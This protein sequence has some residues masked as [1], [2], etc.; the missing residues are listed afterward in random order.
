MWYEVNIW[1]LKQESNISFRKIINSY[2]ALGLRRTLSEKMQTWNWTLNI[3][4]FNPCMQCW[5]TPSL[6]SENE[7]VSNSKGH[8]WHRKQHIYS[9][10]YREWQRTS[11]KVLCQGRCKSRSHRR[12]IKASETISYTKESYRNI[13]MDSAPTTLPNSKCYGDKFCHWKNMNSFYSL[14][15]QYLL[16][17]WV[18]KATLFLPENTLPRQACWQYFSTHNLPYSH[19]LYPDSTKHTPK[20]FEKKYVSTGMERWL[21]A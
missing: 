6:N 9:P 8:V 2:V 1:T 17:V 11:E 4:L 12:N 19:V 3:L 7:L 14:V 18:L 10:Y 13:K 20:A 5:K 21:R 15:R 16:L